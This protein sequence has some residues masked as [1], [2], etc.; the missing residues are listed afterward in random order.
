MNGVYFI[1]RLPC[2]IDSKKNKMDVNRPTDSSVKLNTKSHWMKDISVPSNSTSAFKSGQNKPSQPFGLNGT[3][4]PMIIGNST[5]KPIVVGR[6]TNH[7][8][9]SPMKF[10]QKLT[11]QQKRQQK[12]QLQQQ[13]QRQHLQ[14]LQ[15]RMMAGG[16]NDSNEDLAQA[17]GAKIVATI[18]DD[19]AED[20]LGVAETYAD[21]KPAKLKFGAPHPDAVVETSTLSS[22]EPND[23]TYELSIPKRVI[24]RGCLSALQLESIVY[25]SQ[26]HERQLPGGARAGF[27]IGMKMNRLISNNEIFICIL[28][29]CM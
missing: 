8:V 14:Q 20:Q 24:T 22:I 6:D 23:I 18:D 29:L 4:I 12:K 15:Q 19:K 2:D 28:L 11:K 16:M 25:A 26:A 5:I 17:S 21:Y 1:F 27:L 7:N 9:L 13:Q 10:G 3:Q